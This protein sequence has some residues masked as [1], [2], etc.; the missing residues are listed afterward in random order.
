M[1]QG[2]VSHAATVQRMHLLAIAATW[3]Q[4]Y[5]RDTVRRKD[6]R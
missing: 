4:V 1:D 5:F 6:G 2:Y 3:S